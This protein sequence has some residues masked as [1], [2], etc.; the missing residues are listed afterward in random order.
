MPRNVTRSYTLRHTLRTCCGSRRA[1]APGDPLGCGPWPAPTSAWRCPRLPHLRR[2]AHRRDGAHRRPLGHRGDAPTGAAG[3][4]V[5]RGA[6][7]PGGRHGRHDVRRGG[8]RLAACQIGVDLAV[9]VYDCPD[10]SGT[11]HRGVVCNPVV[12]LPEGRERRLDVGDEGCLLPRGV[13]RV[14]P[15]RPRAGLGTGW[16]ASPWPSRETACSPAA[17]STR[18]TTP[19]APSSATGSPTRLARSCP[20]RWRRRPRTTRPGG[21]SA[22]RGTPRPALGS[23]TDADEPPSAESARR[24]SSRAGEGSST[25]TV[26]P[27]PTTLSIETRPSCWVTS[28][29]TLAR[30]RPEPPSFSARRPRANSLKIVSRSPGSMPRPWSTTESRTH[31]GRAR[32]K[33]HLDGGCPTGST[34]VSSRPGW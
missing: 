27:S 14:R 24:A 15:A 25:V 20:S 32:P 9:F 26:V 5:R 30:P 19:T 3:H 33:V 13:R 12:E 11:L 6:A 2:A 23:R 16:T 21:R 34:S 1:K 4:G 8:R 22:R 29:R 10:E 17:C 7:H 18:P 31:P 28:S